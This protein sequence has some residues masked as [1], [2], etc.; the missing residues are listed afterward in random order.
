MRRILLMVAAMLIPVVGL[1]LGISGTAGASTIKITCT[2]ITGNSSSTIVISGCTGGNT[3][4]S[5]SALPAAELA[6]GGAV[7]WISGSV[8]TSNKPV[9]TGVSA[10]H[11]PGY[12]K[13][14]PTNPS[15]E[16]FTATVASDTGDG[17]L[18]PATE[19]GEVCVGTGGAITILKKLT[20]EWSGSTIACTTITGNESSN[21]TV[22]GCTGGHT[23][24]GSVSLPAATLA[25]GGTITWLSGGSTTIGKPTISG[26]SASKC[27]GYV[28][29][30]AHNPTAEKISTVV[31]SDTGDGLKLPGSGKGEV[32]ITY[33]G[34]I[35]A[36]GTLSIK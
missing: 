19:A 24:G 13:N 18:L 10:S 7:D 29:N 3:G 26:T 22:G 20:I 1:T 16:S 27:P 32:C 36:V 23:G 9:L 21:I 30:A 25:T 4:G 34:A 33:A 35:S 28:K 8:T 15:A 11:C 17:M 31:T 12:V 6:N 2:T 14:A 5:S